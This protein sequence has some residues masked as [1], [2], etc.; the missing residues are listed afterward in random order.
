MKK[1]RIALMAA[2]AAAAISTFPSCCGVECRLKNQQ[3]ENQY[4]INADI[5]TACA[6]ASRLM[7][8]EGYKPYIQQGGDGGNIAVVTGNM[9][10]KDPVKNMFVSAA[11]KRA[12]KDRPKDN[13]DRVDLEKTI[14]FKR[15]WD[16][17]GEE[18][19]ENELGMS[20][21]MDYSA[22]NA[23]GDILDSWIKDNTEPLRSDTAESLIE[24]IK[25]Y[26]GS[27]EKNGE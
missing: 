4:V 24:F 7:E 15:R 14:V 22:K 12:M 19:S 21:S 16:A 8:A 26:E 9:S 1:Y 13:I 23:N 27:T 6:C 3:A 25:Q 11:I 18:F 5:E 17:S 20:V 2:F 10:A